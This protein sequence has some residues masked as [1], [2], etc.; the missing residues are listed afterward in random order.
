MVFIHAPRSLNPTPTQF[1]DLRAARHLSY[2]NSR[3]QAKIQKRDARIAHVKDDCSVLK[4]E[5]EKEG[6]EI[7]KLEKEPRT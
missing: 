2:R 6:E 7:A 5:L 3:Y 4:L 1:K